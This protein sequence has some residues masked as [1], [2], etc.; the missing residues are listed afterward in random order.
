MGHQ[1]RPSTP[2]TR[3]LKIAESCQNIVDANNTV[4]DYI[5]I[6]FSHT[7]SANQA[8]L[9]LYVAQLIAH[10]KI[11]C[12]GVYLPILINLPFPPGQVD[13][14]L[15]QNWHGIPQQVSPGF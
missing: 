11:T 1:M 3:I 14:K 12:K 13:L 6:C 2:T 4:P 10:I 15:S 7:K 5:G 9:K 8:D